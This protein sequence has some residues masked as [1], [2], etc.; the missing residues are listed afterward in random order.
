MREA[1][2][3]G[4][5]LRGEEGAVDGVRGSISMSVKEL[6][7]GLIDMIVGYDTQ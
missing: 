2:V 7:L 1:K 5:S 6:D 4:G 3:G